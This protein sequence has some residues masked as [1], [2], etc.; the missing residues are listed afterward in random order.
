VFIP[1]AN[2]LANINLEKTQYYRM[3]RTNR[4]AV[5][6]KFSHGTDDT[7]GEIL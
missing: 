5:Y 4:N 3:A 6:E 2:A 7:R 1:G